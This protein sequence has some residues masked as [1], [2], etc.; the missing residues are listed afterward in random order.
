MTVAD[1]IKELREH[2][3]MTQE[4]LAKRMGYTGKSSISK[5]ETSGN[6]ITLKKIERLAPILHTSNAYL[7][8][9]TD[10]PSPESNES[11]NIADSHIFISSTPGENKSKIEVSQTP[12]QFSESDDFFM[13]LPDTEKEDL[14]HLYQMYQNARPDVRSAVEILLKAKPQES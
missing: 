9:W 12:K 2:M 6:N 13:N 3:G 14:I 5:I 8:G 10:D 11:D 4:E 1:R 7:M